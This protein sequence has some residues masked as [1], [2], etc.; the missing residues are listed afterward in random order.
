VGGI[1]CVVDAETVGRPEQGR[2]T[3]RGVLV[4]RSARPSH[5]TLAILGITSL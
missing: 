2:V 3:D 1:F 4:V 5:P